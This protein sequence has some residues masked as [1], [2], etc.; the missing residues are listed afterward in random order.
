VGAAAVAGPHKDLAIFEHI[1]TEWAEVD[2]WLAPMGYAEY[3]MPRKLYS[4]IQ[5][6]TPMLVTVVDA[7]GRDELY[8]V[9][10]GSL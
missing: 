3:N 7:K 4:M 9:R 5:R 10:A 2:R 1:L 8:D 6:L